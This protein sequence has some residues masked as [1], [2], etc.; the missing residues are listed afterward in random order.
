MLR[1]TY[2]QTIPPDQYDDIAIGYRTDA[3]RVSGDWHT[4][5]EQAAAGQWTTPSEL[6]L[7]ASELLRARRGESTCV[8][9]EALVHEML[10]PDE[11]NWGLGPGI[12]DD[13]ESFQHGGSNQGFRST[14][15]AY[16]D[17]DD[18]VFAMTISDAGSTLANEIAI[19]VADAYRWSG[20]R[21]AEVLPVDLTAEVRRR[22]VGTYVVA[23]TETEFRVELDGQGLA[24]TWQGGNALLWPLSDSTFFDIDDA[25]EV[26]C[27]GEGAGMEL[28]LG[29][30]KVPRSRR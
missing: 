11:D 14:F 26:W 9:G 12:S 4:Y 10:T 8:L 28:V 3:T 25:R 23:E 24:L 22:Y 1:S 18:G 20:R 16:I 27:S 13:G 30:L 15:A 5:P 6:A 19:T 21:T 17:G 29:S 7:F 2:E